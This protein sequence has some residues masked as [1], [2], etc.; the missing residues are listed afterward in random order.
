[1]KQSASSYSAL[2]QKFNNNDLEMQFQLFAENL[3]AVPKKEQP[4]QQ[5]SR[6]RSALYGRYLN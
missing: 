5:P 1:M 2:S 3:K 4:Q 6:I